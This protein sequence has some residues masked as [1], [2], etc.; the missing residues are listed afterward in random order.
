MYTENKSMMVL[1]FRKELINCNLDKKIYSLL[2][3]N[4]ASLNGCL[5]SFLCGGYFIKEILMEV[6]PP[7]QMGGGSTSFTDLR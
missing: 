4:F 5:L 1:T 3:R 7:F 6:H 2:Y